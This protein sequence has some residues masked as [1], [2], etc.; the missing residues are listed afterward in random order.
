MAACLD[1]RE[2]YGSYYPVIWQALL[3]SL[4]GINEPAPKSSP[5]HFKYRTVLRKQVKSASLFFPSSMNSNIRSCFCTQLVSGMLHLLSLRN[6]ED[7]LELQQMLLPKAEYLLD[8]CVS[9]KKE[10][11]K[12]RAVRLLSF[13]SDIYLPGGKGQQTAYPSS[14]GVFRGVWLSGGQPVQGTV[15]PRGRGPRMRAGANWNTCEFNNY[16]CIYLQMVSF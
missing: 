5:D 10:L 8:L 11:R 6:Q 2:R 15:A 13:V 14:R 7:F 4:E 9:A 16:L 12:V 3:V 1:T